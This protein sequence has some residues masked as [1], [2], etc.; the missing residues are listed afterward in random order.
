MRSF[1]CCAALCAALSAAL[2]ARAGLELE[3][4]T[5]AGQLVDSAG[6]VDRLVPIIFVVRDG[7]AVIDQV[8]DD[9]F[10]VVDGNL[11]VD[12]LVNNSD[13]LELDVIVDGESLGNQTL[14]TSW[15][16]ALYAERA[17]VADTADTADR[18]GDVTTPLTLTDL[19]TGGAL[20]IP[21]ANVTGFPAAF[22]DG[23]QGLTFAPDEASFTFVDGVLAL[24]NGSLTSAQL[25][26]VSGGDLARDAVTSAKLVDGTIASADFGESL[27]LSKIAAGTLLSRHFGT[28]ATR[29]QLYVVAQTDCTQAVGTVTT[30]P[31]CRFTGGASCVAG[32]VGGN[33]INGTR[34]CTG[35]CRIGQTS[36]CANTPFGAAVFK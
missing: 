14:R 29:T 11:I 1:V 13:A 17:D 7:G 20:A 4:V 10:D 12:L 6:P 25:A 3:S 24:K 26:S 16:F 28:S 2:P 23:D 21:L 22:A 33:P 35:E 31:V 34:T 18:V 15:P 8:E 32:N 5:W 19:V 27:P 9:S 30:S 36:D